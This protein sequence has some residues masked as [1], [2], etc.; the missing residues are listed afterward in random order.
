MVAI[1]NP[2]TITD[3]IVDVIG[4]H[5][6]FQLMPLM[7]VVAAAVFFYAKRHYAH[8]IKKFNAQAARQGQTVQAQSC[9]MGNQ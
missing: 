4:L 9:N 8:D 7:S 2:A 3:K 5:Q 6:A 1:A